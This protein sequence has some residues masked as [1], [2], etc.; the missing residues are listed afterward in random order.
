[1]KTFLDYLVHDVVVTYR[2]DDVSS[3]GPS[4]G[5]PHSHQYAMTGLALSIC[6]ARRTKCPMSAVRRAAGRL[7]AMVKVEEREEE[8][9]G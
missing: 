7:L 6:A 3:V 4:R 1:M 5:R 9:S 2:I 8:E